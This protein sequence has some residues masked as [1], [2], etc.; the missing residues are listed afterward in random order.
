MESNNSKYTKT[1]KFLC[2]YGG[3][4]LPRYTD[5]TLRYAGGLTHV[6]AV[7]RSIS[8]T[9]LMMKLGEFCGSSV[10]L[11]CQL[12]IGDLETLISIT[13]GDRLRCDLRRSYLRRRP[14]VDSQ[15]FLLRPFV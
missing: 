14:A 5:G 6:L 12:P 3:K 8:F 11:R 1:I 10:N 9:E 15:S 7:D 4:I 2:S 13:S